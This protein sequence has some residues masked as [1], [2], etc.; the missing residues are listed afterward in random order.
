[1]EN[2]F[3][4][5]YLIFFLAVCWILMLVGVRAYIFNNNVVNNVVRENSNIIEMTNSE[6]AI[7][8]IVLELLNENNITIVHNGT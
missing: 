8:E 3:L 2:P 4:S 7:F 5:I 1:M 6:L